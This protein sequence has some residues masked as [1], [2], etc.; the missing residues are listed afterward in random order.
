MKTVTEHC[1]WG[2]DYSPC[3]YRPHS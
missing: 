2:F 3:L 1:I